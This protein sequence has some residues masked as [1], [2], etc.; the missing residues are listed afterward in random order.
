VNAEMEESKNPSVIRT[1]SMKT[2][3]ANARSLRQPGA[4][5]TFFTE[6]SDGRASFFQAACFTVSVIASLVS[7]C[8]QQEL[9]LRRCGAM[10][11]PFVKQS[12]RF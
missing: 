5:K 12:A 6:K 11:C 9:S 8:H 4:R 7:L 10:Y 3:D 2:R 1:C